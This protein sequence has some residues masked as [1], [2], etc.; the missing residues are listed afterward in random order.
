V[1]YTYA[2]EAPDWARDP[3]FQRVY[4][5]VARVLAGAGKA[6]L[7]EGFTRTADG[8]LANELVPAE[9]LARREPPQRP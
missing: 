8:W 9:P 2:V 5:A 7:K 1:A 4:P 6:E 3:A